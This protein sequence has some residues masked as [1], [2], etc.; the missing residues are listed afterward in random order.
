MT[1][2]NFCTT[3]RAR[4]MCVTNASDSCVISLHYTD[5]TSSNKHLVAGTAA[6]RTPAG[7]DYL[8]VHVRLLLRRVAQSS[9]SGYSNKRDNALCIDIYG[10]VQFRYGVGTT[11]G[12]HAII[13]QPRSIYFG[14]NIMSTFAKNLLTARGNV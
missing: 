13:Q 6:L 10:N 5:H 2:S 8:L 12:D 9:T 7:Y 1:Y 4:P 14:I 3:S 11:V